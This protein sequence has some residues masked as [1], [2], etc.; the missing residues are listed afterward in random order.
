MYILRSVF[1]AVV[2]LAASGGRALVTAC[3]C[4]DEPNV[5]R[6]ISGSEVAVAAY[7]YRGVRHVDGYYSAK[8][9]AVYK[10]CELQKYEKILINGGTKNSCGTRLYKNSRYVLFGTLSHEHVQGYHGLQKGTST[11]LVLSLKELSH[12]CTPPICPLQC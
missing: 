1:A 5:Q 8:V 9:K 12:L 6:S 3:R 10:G 2:F 4:Y 7:V 11:Q